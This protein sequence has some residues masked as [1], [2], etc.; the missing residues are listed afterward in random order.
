MSDR[1]F[2]QTHKRIF[3]STQRAVLLLS[4]PLRVG[5]GMNHKSGVWRGEGVGS[6][7][8]LKHPPLPLVALCSGGQIYLFMYFHGHPMMTQGTKGSSGVAPN[9]QFFRPTPAGLTM[10]QLRTIAQGS[11]LGPSPVVQ[12]FFL[13]NH[14]IPQRVLLRNTPSPELET[15]FPEGLG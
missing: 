5:R 1:E 10:F 9:T 3:Q 12:S 7:S 11:G 15:H 13:S 2:W 8:P 6:R 14:G 4:D